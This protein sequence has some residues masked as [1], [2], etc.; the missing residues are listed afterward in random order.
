VAE[1]PETLA[2]VPRETPI[3]G[4]EV[5]LLAEDDPRVRALARTVLRRS[6]YSVLEAQDGR[7]AVA[8]AERHRGPIHMILTDVVMPELGGGPTVEHLLALKP[9]AKVLYISGYTDDAV[10]RQ[11]LLL[12]GAQYLEKPFTPSALLRKVREVLDRP[13]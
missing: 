13:V 5:I 12:P 11:G 10:A 8:L 6:G 7:E 1:A 2:P 4:S 9:G 3:G